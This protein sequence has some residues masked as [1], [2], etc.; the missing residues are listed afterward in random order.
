MC[1][2]N[3]LTTEIKQR[4]IMVNKPSNVLK[5]QLHSPDLKRHTKCMLHGGQYTITRFVH[6]TVN[7][8]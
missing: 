1:L 6:S 3:Y 2:F 8:T 7:Y 5:K 4:I